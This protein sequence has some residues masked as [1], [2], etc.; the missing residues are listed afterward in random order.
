MATKVQMRSLEGKSTPSSL[1]Y[2]I[3][4]QGAMQRD[5]AKQTGIGCQG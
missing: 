1:A 5:W 3:Q 2:A 4:L